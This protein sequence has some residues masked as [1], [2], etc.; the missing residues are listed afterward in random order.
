MA[1]KMITN[2]RFFFFFD[3]SILVKTTRIPQKTPEF[4]KI[5]MMIFMS[6]LI[7]GLFFLMH[8]R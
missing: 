4:Q 3:P 8:E 7:F 1:A 5:A 6:E 2:R